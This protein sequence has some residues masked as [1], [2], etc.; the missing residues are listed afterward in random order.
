LKF[1]TQYPTAFFGEIKWAVPDFTFTPPPFVDLPY[2]DV[3]N[4]RDT[5]SYA[6]QAFLAGLRLAVTRGYDEIMWLEDDCCVCLDRWDSYPWAEYEIWPGAVCGGTPVVHNPIETG[7]AWE[8]PFFTYAKRYQDAAGV[9][10]AL[11]GS[12]PRND[13]RYKKTMKLYPNGAFGIY[14]VALLKDVFGAALKEFVPQRNRV[15][16]FDL[17]VGS[18]L[19]RTYGVDV[20][21]RV[22][23]TPS[24]YS[25]CGDGHI[26]WAGRQNLLG[27]KV[28]VHQWNFV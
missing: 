12:E 14:K 5:D 28:G 2:D 11:E 22:A 18:F 7:R 8:M 4:F 25:G 9:P 20:F 24:T 26:D 23:F 15:I 3:P 13:W 17:T 1:D 16:Y 21:N 6:I 19:A 10:M 27:K